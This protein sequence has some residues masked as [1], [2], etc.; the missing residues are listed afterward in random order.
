MTTVPATISERVPVPAPSAPSSGVPGSL[1]PGDIFRI[2]RG[3]LVLIIILSVFLT[4]VLTGLF[5]LWFIKYPTYSADALI[6]CISNAPKD[7]YAVTSRQV[8]KDEHER[9]LTDQAYYFK[10]PDLLL[11]VL[12]APEV[13]NT[14]WYKA[15]DNVDERFTDLESN[16]AAYPVRDSNY[17]NVTIGTRSPL[18][19]HIIVR[20]A[21]EI[22]LRE[23]KEGALEEW[24]DD[25]AKYQDEA[26]RL[27]G[28][29]Q[30]QMKKME[31]FAKDIP[32]GVI[33][34]RDRSTPTVVETELLEA[35]RQVTELELQTIELEGIQSI[36]TNPRGPGVTAEDRQLVEL[37]P[38]VQM[39]RNQ[40]LQLIQT[41]Q[42]KMERFGKNHRE[43]EQ[44]SVLLQQVRTQLQQA[45]DQKLRESIQLKSEQVNTALFSSQAALYQAQDRLMEAKARQKDIES[46]LQM[47]ARLTD[48][49]E[50]LKETREKVDEYVQ[51]IERI[52]Q[53]QS[54]IQVK[55]VQWPLKPI[56]RSLPRW[57][58]V[59]GAP[60][61][62]LALAIGFAFLL[63]LLDTSVRTPRDVARYLNIPILGT[64]PDSDDEEVDIERIETAVKEWPN[65]MMAEAFRAVRT[66]LQFSAPPERQRLV[67]VTS[68][69]PED[70]KTTVACNLAA[71]LALGG[72]R[73]LLVDANFRRP[74]LHAVF[75]L[76]NTKGLSNILIGASQM[77]GA[78]VKTD[79]ANLDVLPSG[80]TPPNP[81]ERLGSPLMTQFLEEAT[82]T[83]DQIIL[84]APPVLLASDASVISTLV[85]G[86]IL[87]IRAKENSRGIAQRSVTV[88]KHVN[89][90]VFGAV[91]NA[92]QA[93]RGGYFREQLRTFY[94]Y[95]A[96]GELEAKS[97]ADAALPSPDAGSDDD[98]PDS[99]DDTETT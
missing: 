5:L 88:L 64:V 84:D 40:E 78:I 72:R 70:G 52:I 21:V 9:F 82:R 15:R 86:A 26:T 93:Q 22:Y 11:Q 45:R 85:D 31:A 92:A 28:Q 17:V 8:Q 43:V 48:E 6:Q 69:S 51:E 76:P 24:R 49:L 68:P 32:E 54:A 65:S 4:I 19:P 94:D 1:T 30:Q 41:L 55:V 42:A 98:A 56:Q 44:L 29:I 10:Q 99:K 13:K 83:Y 80:P 16:L 2:I 36:Y 79:L 89:A 50:F 59:V 34:S 67:L 77:D 20:K 38:L 27:Q 3:R 71:S 60:M 66:A 63:E 37:N 18:D 58:F 12:Q 61:L 47:Y 33:G 62:A 53:K 25:L 35:Q 46:K 87:V 95:Q 74:A 57:Y 7:P 39:L 97:F 91:L 96:E 73:I 90:H 14:S 81:A 75:S 23:A